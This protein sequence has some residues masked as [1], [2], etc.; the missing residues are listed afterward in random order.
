MK[1]W[2][3]VV[4]P[5]R[6]IKNGDFNASV[7][8]ADLGD[9]TIGE[10]P[11]D[12]NDPYIFY[13]KTYLTDGLE[14]LLRDTK[15]KL[16]E[17]TGN[18]ITEIRTPFGG[19]KTHSLLALYHFLEN[20][21]DVESL[22]PDDLSPID[23]KT[24]VVVGT[25][26]NPLNGRDVGETT[27]YTLWGEIAYQIGG[28]EGYRQFEENDNARVAPG[29]DD[30]KTFLRDQQPF[31]LL[32][33]EVLQY[34][35]KAA[36]V[37]LQEAATVDETT[38]EIE[39][40]TL[41]S[42]TYA[43][44][45]ELSETVSS[46]ERSSMV[47]TLPSSTMEDYSDTQEEGLQRLRKVM[48]RVKSIETP[49][50]GEEVYSIIRRRLFDEELDEG[51]RNEI[52]TE[53]FEMYRDLQDELPPKARDQDYK[54]KI[55]L[56][57]P[58]HPDVIDIL[59]EKWGT[60][61]NFQRTRGVLQLLANVVE[62]L[63]QSERNID[64]ILPCDI[65]LDNNAVRQEFV[66]YIGDEYESVIGSDIAGS[67][68]KAQALDR[69]NRNWNHL[70]ERISTTIFVHSFTADDSE[71]GVTMPYIKLATLRTETLPPMVTE[72]LQKLSRELWYLNE[73][74]ERY[75]FSDLP[76]LNRMVLDKKS[77]YEDSYLDEA[78]Q[79]VRDELGNEIFNTYL[80][81]N[82]SD[83]IPDNQ[84][85][86]LVVLHPER[87]V[88]DLDDWVES[89]GENFRENRN[90]LIFALPD[91]T[92]FAQFRDDVME[93]LALQ[94]IES[95]VRS[96]EM[97]A[98]AEKMDEIESRIDEIEDDFSYNIRRV[99]HTAYIGGETV[100]L[101]QP[102]TGK[103]SIANWYGR[104]LK[105]REKVAPQVHQNFLI[106]TFLGESDRISTDDL[107]EQ[108]YKDTDLF[109]IES[110]E[111][112]EEAIL[113]GITVGDLGLVYETENGELDP[114]KVRFDER[115]SQGQ[116][117]WTDD[118][119]VI[120]KSLAQE[121]LDQLEDDEEDDEVEDDD[122]G[123]EVSV[124][125]I[126]D[127]DGSETVVGADDDDGSEDGEVE[128]EQYE[129]VIL[130]VSDL[131]PNKLADINRGIIIPISSEAEDVGFTIQ[132]EIHDNSVPKDLVENRVR[133]AVNQLGGSLEVR[134]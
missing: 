15:Q 51:A 77:L 109:M 71:K 43:F 113:N 114:E 133:E 80:W 75:F 1:N 129:N 50:K 9:V 62:E 92:R 69:E 44:L 35:T 101:G 66:E 104:E 11:A 117:A 88:G 39:G 61:P 78:E 59:Y 55:E 91:D 105:E 106:N 33:D 112:I 108:F 96:G 56:S 81:P 110:K 26:L 36:N 25:H 63:Y 119:Y 53:Y 57:Y 98:L 125:G 23:A 116:V 42:Q 118:E 47:V 20:G 49:V 111:T 76:N 123:E 132:L 5:H 46:L 67:D 45:Q 64:M 12:Y 82:S 84:S 128:E 18:S 85:L 28:I 60:Y 32:M 127:D 83:Q 52:V 103:E 34:M 87:E 72:V 94:E 99:Y 10:A 24:A 2:Y 120:T 121:L 14:N 124:G 22:L 27:I 41:R 8:A 93:Y 100:D 30:L 95:D 115:L 130:H 86:K 16:V 40:E 37:P 68:S 74:N 70:A 73:R 65:S 131:P 13:K 122:E 102:M 6:D 31:V 79:I 19:G 29:K 126:T 4:E 21:N 3:D 48:G 38:D 90:T 134:E 58:F 89:K 54:Q 97:E 7:F 17:G 107:V